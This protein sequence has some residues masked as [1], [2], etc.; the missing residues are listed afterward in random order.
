MISHTIPESPCADTKIIPDFPF[1]GSY[2]RTVIFQLFLLRSEIALRHRRSLKVDRHIS[3]GQV[4]ATFRRSVNR[5]SSKM[6]GGRAWAGTS[7][8]REDWDLVHQTDLSA[9]RP[10][11]CN[12]RCVW[13]T[14]S[15]S[16]RLSFILPD[17]FSCRHENL[18]PVQCGQTKKVKE[19]IRT[20]NNLIVICRE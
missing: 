5:F 18:F 15:N 3:P 11:W 1:V 14:C 7:V 17:T 16:I 10:L 9:N 8:R 2:R 20:T 4:S 12:V 19:A 6:S 13:T